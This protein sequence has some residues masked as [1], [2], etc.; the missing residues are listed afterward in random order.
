M[1][2]TVGQLKEQLLAGLKRVNFDETI[3]GVLPDELLWEFQAMRAAED[4]AHNLAKAA[5][6]KNET[7]KALKTLFWDKVHAIP[8]FQAAWDAED[9]GGLGIASSTDREIVIIQLPK[10]AGVQKTLSDIL[11]GL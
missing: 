5:L 2:Q 11:G 7:T 10:G 9:S 3:A 4:E 8:A 1:S 6:A